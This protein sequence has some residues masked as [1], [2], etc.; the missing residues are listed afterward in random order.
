[1]GKGRRTPEDEEA[2]IVLSVMHAHRKIAHET[3]YFVHLMS[4]IKFIKRKR[5]EIL[6]SSCKMERHGLESLR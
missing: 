3:H 4:Q 5:L 6:E 2:R 1:M